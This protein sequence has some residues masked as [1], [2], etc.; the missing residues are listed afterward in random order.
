M[1]YRLPE[2]FLPRVDLLNLLVD[3]AFQYL[4]RQD[5]AHFPSKGGAVE[6]G[7]DGGVPDGGQRLVMADVVVLSDISNVFTYL[8]NCLSYEFPN[9][10]R[11]IGYGFFCVR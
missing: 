7:K 4:M 3:V 6:N 11:P 10:E 8:Q 2:F 1:C 5:V 9:E